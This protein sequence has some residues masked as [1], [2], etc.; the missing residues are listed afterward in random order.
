MGNRGSTL[1]IGFLCVTMA[2]VYSSILLGRSVWEQSQARGF[3]DA[4]SAFQLAE[5]GIDDGIKRLRSDYDWTATVTSA[6][7]K[8]GYQVTVTPD[9]ARRIIDSASTVTGNANLTARLEAVVQR[10]IPPHFYDNAIYASE[11]VVLKGN[12]YSIV[13]NVRTGSDDP[14]QNAGNVQG[15]VIYDP[16]ADPLPR[17]EF[18]QLYDLAQSQGNV[19]DDARLQEI[20]RGQD[21]FPA[22]FCYSPPTDPADPSTCMPN[23]N[24]ITEDLVL[25]GNIGTIGG[26]FV[27]VGDVLTNPSATEDTTINGVGSVDGAIYTTGDFVINGGGGGLN[28]YGGVW[29]GDEARLNGNATVEYEATYLRAIERLNLS[30]DVQLLSWRECPAAGC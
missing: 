12:A 29:A 7:P 17:F 5:A 3:R 25:N 2:L 6:F 27:V 20:Q 21:A 24:Y 26:F 8:G 14:V 15:D 9:G 16:N 30:A 10:A 28:V 13:G 11:E 23:I 18:Q 19:Y 1:V 22:E 4:A